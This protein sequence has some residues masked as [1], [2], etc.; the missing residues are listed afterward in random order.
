MSFPSSGL[1]VAGKLGGCGDKL[2]KPLVLASHLPPPTHW[3]QLLPQ[4]ASFHLL[5]A[6]ATVYLGSYHTFVT[7]TGKAHMYGASVLSWAHLPACE[8]PMSALSAVDPF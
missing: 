1:L 7:V 5:W 8:M 3:A 6:P 2:T 4:A